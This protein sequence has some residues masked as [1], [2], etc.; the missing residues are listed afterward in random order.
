[1][2]L[3]EGFGKRIRIAGSVFIQVEETFE[4]FGQNLTDKKDPIAGTKASLFT[5]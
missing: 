4:V 5:Q 1:M 3:I 2:R